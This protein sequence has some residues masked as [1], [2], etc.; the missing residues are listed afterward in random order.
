MLAGAERDRLLEAMA[1]L[2]TELGDEETPRGSA[3]EQAAADSVGRGTF[4]GM[5]SDED[6]ELV[7]AINAALA[8]IVGAVASQHPER[9]DPLPNAIIGALG[10][11]EMVM[12]AEII[13]GHIDRLASLLP[14]FAYVATLPFVG[15]EEALRLSRRT[16]ELLDGTGQG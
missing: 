15:E 14:G 4:A 12:R 5:L 9:V 6:E 11:A 13:D 1:A 16:E 7:A 3:A 10:G 8:K 2:Y